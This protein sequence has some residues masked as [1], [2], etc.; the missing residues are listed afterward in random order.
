MQYCQGKLALGVL[1]CFET[2]GGFRNPGEKRLIFSL[3]ELIHSSQLRIMLDV[4]ECMPGYARD[5]VI[6][7]KRQT[8]VHEADT[9][10]VARLGFKPCSPEPAG[11]T[12]GAQWERQCLQP[13]LRVWVAP[14]KNTQNSE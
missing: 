3:P 8:V 6:L 9:E 13:L 12:R 14:C 2:D 1:E 10:R 4:K 7:S 5:G 11:T